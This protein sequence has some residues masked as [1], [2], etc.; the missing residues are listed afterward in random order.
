MAPL[1]T[2]TLTADEQSECQRLWRSTFPKADG[3]WYLR[4]DIVEPFNRAMIAL[5]MMGRADRFAILS[6]PA[7]ACEAAAKAC[8][9]YPLSAYFFDLA[10]LLENAGREADAKTMFDEFLRRHQANQPDAVDRL[11]LKTRDLPAM[12]STPQALSRRHAHALPNRG[13]RLSIWHAYER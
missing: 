11:L 5:C 4:P 2:V 9:I 6:R 1:P 10:C 12:V 8:A 13:T 3:A 7:D